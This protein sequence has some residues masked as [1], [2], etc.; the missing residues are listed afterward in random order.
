MANLFRA[1][2]ESETVY[3]AFLTVAMLLYPLVVMR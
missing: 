2:V 1:I 3:L